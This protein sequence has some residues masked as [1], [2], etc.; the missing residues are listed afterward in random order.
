MACRSINSTLCETLKSKLTKRAILTVEG[1]D[2]LVMKGKVIG[3][4][5][6]NQV[7]PLKQSHIELLK[8]QQID[9]IDNEKTLPI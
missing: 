6:G 4:F 7:Y 8:N 5:D 9:I 1:V 3:Y 2:F